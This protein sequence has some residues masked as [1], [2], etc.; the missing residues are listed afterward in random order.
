MAT[1]IALSRLSNMQRSSKQQCI[2]PPSRKSLHC[3]PSSIHCCKNGNVGCR[4]LY[5]L[6]TFVRSQSSRDA[7]LTTDVVSFGRTSS[8]EGCCDRERLTARC[9]CR[10]VICS[11]P[12]AICR[13]HHLADKAVLD[14]ELGVYLYGWAVAGR[15][16]V[17]VFGCK[18]RP[19]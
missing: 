2:I 5:N 14:T 13:H 1:P 4:G 8:E 6:R 9:Y 18:S 15:S 17:V 11:G 3:R 19:E 12:I 10:P 7:H 16:T